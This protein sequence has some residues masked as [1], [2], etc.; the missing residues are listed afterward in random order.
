MSAWNLSHL[1]LSS[2]SSLHIRH[3]YW[4][5]PVNIFQMCLSRFIPPQG[6]PCHFTEIG[7]AL[8]IVAVRWD[9]PPP[10]H[11][12]PC[13]LKARLWE[14]SCFKPWV[15]GDHPQA[16]VWHEGFCLAPQASPAVLRALCL[17]LPGKLPLSVGL[18]TE[19]LRVLH[20][21]VWAFIL[22]RGF[23]PGDLCLGPQ[24]AVCVSPLGQG[25]RWSSWEPW[26]EGGFFSRKT[27]GMSTLL[28][29]QAMMLLGP[30][31]PAY[32]RHSG[33]SPSPL[34]IPAAC[35]AGEKP[36]PGTP[37]HTHLL[38]C[39]LLSC[40]GLG[41]RSPLCISLSHCCGQINFSEC[42]SSSP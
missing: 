22:P 14:L 40:S 29:L 3:P 38:E 20:K 2:V 5:C 1:R 16:G 31:V 27:G 26:A 36:P 11:L 19:L 32:N 33:M 9:C 8:W 12:P 24:T 15:T 42:Q 37:R 23:L 21:S 35:V 39:S 28:D 4:F 30:E 7:V 6:D 13:C 10:P 34:C 17:P 18:R 25:L 41:G